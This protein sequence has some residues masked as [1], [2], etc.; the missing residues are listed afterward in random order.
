MTYIFIVVVG[1]HRCGSDLCEGDDDYA[2]TKDAAKYLY[3]VFYSK[4][5]N[6]RAFSDATR[7]SVLLRLKFEKHSE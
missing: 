2:Q 6:S 1:L 3:C 4:P 7:M 5:R